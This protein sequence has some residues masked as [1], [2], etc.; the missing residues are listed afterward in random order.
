MVK[1]DDNN[2][3]RLLGMTAVML[4]SFLWGTTGTVATFAKDASSF[5][6]GAAALGVC[7]L[8]QATIALRALSNNLT[9]L[10]KHKNIWFLGSMGVAIYALSF[11]SSM[12]FAGVAI[13]SVISLASAPIFSGLL[14]LLIDRKKTQRLVVDGCTFGNC[15]KHLVNCFKDAVQAG[16]WSL[17]CYR[18]CSW[19]C[20]GTDLCRL[21]L[22]DC[23][24]Y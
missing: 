22:G 4:T 9:L 16:A 20:S 18:Y 11:Y 19:P 24:S 1:A 5:A 21:H 17:D 3:E 2:S 23:N 14:E 13:G 10:L 6:I 12:H 15:R 7:G 8:L